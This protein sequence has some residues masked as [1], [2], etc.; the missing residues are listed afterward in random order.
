[1]AV[2]IEGFS[3]VAKNERISNFLEEGLIHPPNSTALSDKHLWR[4]SFMAEAD[5]QKFARSLET[6]LGLNISKGPDSDVVLVSEFDESV[7]PYCEWLKTGRWDKAL[8]GWREGTDPDTVTAMEGWD[9]AKGSGLTFQDPDARKNLRF[10][11]LEENVEVFLNTET[12][13]E[14]YI[15]RTE[16]PV[17]G[18]FNQASEIINEN[19]VNAGGL[20]VRGQAREDVV[21]AKEMLDEVL[22][23]EPNWWN[24]LWFQGKAQIALGNYEDAYAQFSK[25][26]EIESTVE[27]IPRELSG[28]CLELERFEEAVEISE[29]SAALSPA[30]PEILGNLS[31][32]YLLAGRTDAATKTIGAALKLD[33]DDKINQSLEGII[34]EVSRGARPPPKTLKELMTSSVRPKRP[35]W[36][37]W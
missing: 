23:S 27:A 8:I 30:D 7:E 17:D 19:F 10:L 16:T 4:C 32:A 9:P 21:S 13:T 12:N 6:L 2:P 36:K 26:Y 33:K 37:F 15:G 24:A 31:L 5:A 3:V 1:M 18:L 29:G 34:G 25:A 11:R 28:V 14:V 20:Q 22:A 35:F